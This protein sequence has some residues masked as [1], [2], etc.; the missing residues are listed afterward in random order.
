MIGVVVPTLGERPEMLGECLRS[1]RNAGESYISVVC[2]KTFNQDS[3][4]SQGLVD[5]VIT[6][7]GAGLASAINFGIQSLP[8]KV[9]LVSWLGDDDFLEPGSL[10]VL[11]GEILK[12]ESI[13]AA[14]GNCYYIDQEGRRFSSSQF[15]SLAVCLL[16]FGPDLIPQPASAFRREAFQSVGGLRETLKFA[17]DLDLFL[18][19][20]KLGEVSYLPTYLASYRWHKGSLST[21][22]Q[23]ESRAEAREVRANHLP[24][25]LRFFSFLWE[26]PMEA[27]A[28]SFLRLDKLA[29]KSNGKK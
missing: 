17:F 15:G 9:K 10:D 20:S 7:P 26:L 19:L 6:D 28:Q 11:S 18:H 16:P 21:S 4:L 5:Q 12:N 8:T 29:S 1:I 22:H 14:F 27:L 3:I 2:P 25:R 23:A 24:R 13:V